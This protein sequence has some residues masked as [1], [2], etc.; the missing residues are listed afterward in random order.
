MKR[1]SGNRGCQEGDVA[2]KSQG[3][4][5]AA[6]IA[7]VT[8]AGILLPGFRITSAALLQQSSQHIG[9]K[10]EAAIRTRT[11]GTPVA[12]NGKG[13]HLLYLKMF[14]Q[15]DGGGGCITKSLLVVAMTSWRRQEDRQTQRKKRVPCTLKRIWDRKVIGS[16]L[17]RTR[18]L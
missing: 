17:C 14:S 12:H 16:P 11:A 6:S 3:K 2:L 8:S 10:G 13:P 5:R 15:H 7:L 9:Q 18:T 1:L 4:F